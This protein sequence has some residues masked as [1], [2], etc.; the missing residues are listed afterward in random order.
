MRRPGRSNPRQ[1][2]ERD[3]IEL[4]PFGDEALDRLDD[5]VAGRGGA[6][7]GGEG[8]AEARL[9]EAVAAA[10]ASPGGSAAAAGDAI[11]KSVQRFVADRP[12]FDDITL[13]CL[14]RK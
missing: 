13:V 14:A 9:A 5:G 12:Q 10:A 2:D 1:A 8:V 7:G 3:V 6:G 11:V 4:G